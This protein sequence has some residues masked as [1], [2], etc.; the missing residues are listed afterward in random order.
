MVDL[1][2]AEYL[3]DVHDHTIASQ[4]ESVRSIEVDDVEH[5]GEEPGLQTLGRVIHHDDWDDD[6]D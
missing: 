5:S 3:I 1:D 6:E 2:Q 4:N